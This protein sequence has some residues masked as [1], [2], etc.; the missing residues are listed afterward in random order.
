MKVKNNYEYLLSNL[1]KLNGVGK[2]TVEILKKLNIK[3]LFV[4]VL[5]KLNIIGT[6]RMKKN[7]ILLI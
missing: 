2:K 4:V 3:Y 6:I 7:Y 1:T 5:L